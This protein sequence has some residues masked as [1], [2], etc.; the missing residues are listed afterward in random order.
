MIT[1]IILIL[2]NIAVL[3]L[4]MVQRDYLTALWIAVAGFWMVRCFDVENKL[5]TLINLIED[6][7]EKQMK[8]QEKQNE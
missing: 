1:R 7:Y 2:L 8:E 5:Q 3:V 4:S 6:A